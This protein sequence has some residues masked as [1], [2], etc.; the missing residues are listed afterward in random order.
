MTGDRGRELVLPRM[1]R[2]AFVAAC[3]AL[4][5]VSL[6]AGL[7]MRASLTDYGADPDALAATSF[8][9][10]PATP[11]MVEL[12]TTQ[13][14]LEEADE[15][16][17]DLDEVTLEES[18]EFFSM[19]MDNVDEIAPV[20]LVGTFTGERSYVYESFRCVLEVTRVVKGDG[21]EA[22]D[23]ITVYDP[24]M[25]KE[26]GDISDSGGFFSPE[27]EVFPSTGNYTGG[28]PPFREGQEYLL[29]L[30]PKVYPDGL[31]PPAGPKTY[32]QV[33]HPYARIPTDAADHPERCLVIDYD[34]LET[35]EREW[36]FD[37]VMPE[38]TFEEAC[39]YDL[40]VWERASGEVFRATCREILSRVLGA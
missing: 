8:V 9:P 31:E 3:V 6:A 30:E 19:A 11:A 22:G 23:A 20:I 29:F 1:G 2:G 5:A 37:Y 34:S 25:I 33:D 28:M 36:G 14:I 40:I 24:F 7:G 17:V 16:G 13:D 32:V 10:Q 39:G 21:V 35:V 15:A 12:Y 26:P 27:R 38:M 4:L 18:Q